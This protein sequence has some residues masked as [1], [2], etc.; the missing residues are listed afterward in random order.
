M[1]KTWIPPALSAPEQAFEALGND[2]KVSL[3]YYLI[4]NLQ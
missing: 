1:L 3:Q 4:S 2:E